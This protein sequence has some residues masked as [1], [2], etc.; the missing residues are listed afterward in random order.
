MDVD[1]DGSDGDRQPVFEAGSRTYQPFTSYH[2]KKRTPTPSPCV[3]VWEK[4]MA[5]NDAK[6]KDPKTP[7]SEV[8]ALKK[9]NVELRAQLRDLQ[10]Q[11]Y[12]VAALDPFIV[13]PTT[14]FSSKKGPY[15]PR[16]GD[17]CVVI[18]GDVLYPAI[19]GDAG[20]TT[21]IG[22]ASLRLCR[23]INTRA[24]GEYRPMSD[25]KATYLV[26]PNSADKDWGPPDL[27]AW[28]A[29]C[30]A[31]LKELGGHA[32]KFFEWEP[33]PPPPAPPETPAAIP[34][35]ATAAPQQPAAPAPA[36]PIGA[37]K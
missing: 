9:L 28:Q 21:K 25:L 22:E 10:S 20:P 31:L 26:F 36:P 32:G 27:R 37:E 16:I 23:Q 15:V 5:D 24:N 13:L 18:S 17:Y 3:P 7:A 11:S 33:P 1:T 2:W 14:M 34:P 19:I 12:L 6:I 35:A 4:R 29:K 8:Q 30:D